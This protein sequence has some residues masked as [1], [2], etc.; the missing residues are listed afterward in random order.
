MTVMNTIE[1]V[2]IGEDFDY[3]DISNINRFIAYK[4]PFRYRSYYWDYE[5]GLYYL[6]SRY[7]DPELGRFINA[8]SISILYQSQDELNIY[9]MAKLNENCKHYI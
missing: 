6:N 7:Y 1:Y 5:T 9:L 2:D 8:D 3:N 4:N